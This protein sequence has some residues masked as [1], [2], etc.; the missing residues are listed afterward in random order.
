M[1]TARANPRVKHRCK[2]IGANGLAPKER[3]PYPPD[4]VEVIFLF[5]LFAVVY[6]TVYRQYDSEAR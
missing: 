4:V 3:I 2:M 1:S 6:N 5:F